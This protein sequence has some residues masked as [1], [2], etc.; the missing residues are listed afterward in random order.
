[1]E[2]IIEA[3][4]LDFC[5]PD[6]FQAL[7]GVDFQA[8]RGEI[9]ALLGANGCG[10]TTLFQHFNG[11][12]KP[13]QGSIFLK[14]RPFAAYSAEQVFK[15]V[16]LVFQDPNDQL[17]AATVSDDISYGPTNLRLTSG[18]IKTRVNKAMQLMNLEQLAKRSI[19]ALSYGQKKRV[20]IAGM[21]ALEPEVMVLDEPTAGL[22]PVGASKL[23][24]LLR[25]I[26]RDTGVTII[27][28]THDVDL[29][30]IYC[31]RVYVMN[32]GRICLEG[33]PE[34]VFAHTKELRGYNLRLPR[35]AHLVEVLRNKDG[36]E[37]QRP[38]LTISQARETLKEMIRNCQD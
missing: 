15:T 11:L 13:T 20:A 31:D 10:K 35:V 25:T 5:Y 12:H 23:M 4:G 18:E 21:L 22:D 30:P 1:M 8:C 24:Q 32:Q 3:K 17:F 29:V 6:G 38:G 34:A 2:T 9:I 14:G 16:G 33:T 27:L 37:L 26:R 28:S 7:Y 36:W 19:H